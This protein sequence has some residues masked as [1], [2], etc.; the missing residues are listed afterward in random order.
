M[1]YF[2]STIY[3][4]CKEGH[5][6]CGDAARCLRSK[7]DTIMLLC[8]GVGSGIYAN[9]A[10]LTCLGR[11]SELCTSSLSFLEACSLVAN[12]MHRARTENIPFAAFSAVKVFQNGSFRAYTYESPSPILIRKDGK[13]TALESQRFIKAGYE[14]LGEYYGTLEKGD[15]FLMFS[16]GVSQAG[17]GNGYLFGIDSK[18]VAEYIT[19]I[20]DA[21]PLPLLKK[22][23]QMTKDLCGGCCQD[24]TTLAMLQCREATQLTI[25]TGPP[26]GRSKDSEFV[27]RFI[28]TPGMHVVCGSTTADIVA[29]ELGKELKY[30]KP[31][32]AFGAPPEYEI[33]GIDMTT[34]GAMMLNQVYNILDEPV[35]TLTDATPV[36]RLAKLI[37]RADVINLFHGRSMNEAHSDLIFKQIGIRP[38]HIIVSQLEKKLENMGKLVI[39][40]HY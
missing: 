13:A 7:T 2:A 37:H 25:V 9:I 15:R 27:N 1:N 11:L 6:V 21:L 4:E 34:E 36:E 24:D 33:E 23:L 22:I 20:Q 26:Q 16:D 31:G 32:T 8:D 5:P 12:S 29:R 38:R 10:A 17:L 18:G 35:E 28:R 14:V 3:Q 39:M 30:K 40:V 19:E